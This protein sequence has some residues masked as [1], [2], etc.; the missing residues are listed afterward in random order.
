MLPAQTFTQRL[1]PSVNSDVNDI[2]PNDEVELTFSY[3]DPDN[4]SLLLNGLDEALNL[5]A[6]PN[7]NFGTGDFSIE[8]WI[9]TSSLATQ[10]LVSK[11]APG[12]AGY[13]VGLFGG[14]VVAGITDGGGAPIAVN[15]FTP[16]A[17]GTWHHI[18][19]VFDRNDKMTIYTDGF[20]DNDAN[21]SGVGS[22]DNVDLM[23]IGAANSGAGLT[24]HYNGYIDE[25]RVWSA[26]LT[27][28][29]INAR[30]TTHLNPNSVPNLV[31][32]WDMND[33]T[34]PTIIDCSVSGASG[35]MVG[36]A[37]LSAD[38]PVL[39]FPFLP[40]WSNG[41]TGLTQFVSPEDTTQYIITVGYCKYASIDSITINVIECEDSD[42]SGLISSVWVP[43]AFSPNG[44]FKND[45]FMVQGANITYYDIKIFNR[46][47]NIMYHSRNILSGWDGTF[48]GEFVKD[49]VYTYIVTYR[50]R[51]NEEYTKHGTITLLK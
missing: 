15:G 24:T 48:E 40:Q 20:F 22:V 51:F 1:N 35:Q 3:E 27:V 32:Y 50:D 8:C 11:V 5:G 45:I 4:S 43:S 44:D 16:I 26:A 31:G 47:G 6:S 14:F 25:V 30:S 18:V 12:I 39:T 49:D 19:V 29:E 33:V 38:A 28:A 2:C 42:D 37:S 36:S 46:F 9:K 17:D 21:I 7:L 41:Q 13:S 34:A 23:R 10:A